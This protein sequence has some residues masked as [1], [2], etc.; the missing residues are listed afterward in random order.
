MASTYKIVT[1]P[2]DGIGPEVVEQASRVLDVISESGK[3]KF[4]VNAHD[5][6]G[7]AIDNHGNPLPPSTL[8][9]CQEADAILLGSVGGPKWGVGKVRPEQGLLELR[10]TLGLYANIRPALFPSE[11]LV[12]LS[13]LKDSIASGTE[14]IVVR[15]LIGGIYFGQRTEATSFEADGGEASVAKDECSYSVAEIQRIARVAAFLAMTT[16]PPMAVHSVDK[17]N[18]LAT[19]RLWRKV[20]TD[21]FAKEFPQL[22]LDHHLVDSAAML[23]CSNP[24]KLNGIVLTENLFGDVLS[25]ETSVIPGSLGLL[26]SA[27]LAGI[28]DRKSKCLGVYEPIHGSAPDIAGKGIANPVGTILSVALM[29]R[30]SLGLDREAEQVELAVRKVLDSQ[31]T[32]GH[33]LR[34]ADLKG[35]A[36]T[37]QLGDA[38]VSAL[39]KIISS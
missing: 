23:I 24:K 35:Q 12:Q 18:V 28:P 17:A 36:S 7:I 19:S 2:G 15:E 38:V 14:I 9:A 16:S 29:L 22:S 3:V 8:Q 6:G 1:L 26:P 25:D 31:E 4:Q 33:G 5:F 21:L 27:S 20:V 39:K 34:T 11:S 13:P 37:K 10:K 30:Y 32:G